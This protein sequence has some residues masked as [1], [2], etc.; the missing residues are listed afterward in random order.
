[1]TFGARF[2]GAIRLQVA[3]Y[4]EVEADRT[5]TGQAM[6]VVVVAS[7]ASG[8]GLMR[9]FGPYGILEGTLSALIGWF[10]WA[11]LAYAIGVHLLPE[12]QTRSTL[13]EMLRTTGFAAAPGVFRILTISP[14][15]G[16]L[17]AIVV[18]I[19]MLLAMVIAVRQAL[20]YRSTL[21]AI[22]VCFIGWLVYLAF[23]LLFAPFAV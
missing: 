2:A 8:L 17:I 13:G 20:D 18:A 16:A 3:T 23:V 7:I 6:A 12:P 15:C 10:V 5:A 11:L 9:V 4:E 1:M 19:W 21:R 22:G 14:L